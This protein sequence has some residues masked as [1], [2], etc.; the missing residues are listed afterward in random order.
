LSFVVASWSLFCGFGKVSCAEKGTWRCEALQDCGKS[1]GWPTS[2]ATKLFSAWDLLTTF[3]IHNHG[4]E[5]SVWEDKMR[6]SIEE[7]L[8]IQLPFS[9]ARYSAL[10]RV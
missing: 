6:I 4:L 10:I 8:N 2:Q 7:I 9:C 1:E 3:R 5:N